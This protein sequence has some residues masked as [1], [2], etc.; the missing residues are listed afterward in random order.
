[1][2]EKNV[3]FKMNIDSPEES[4]GNKRRAPEGHTFFMK[5]LGIGANAEA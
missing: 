4:G 3:S 2:K 5:S 1:M